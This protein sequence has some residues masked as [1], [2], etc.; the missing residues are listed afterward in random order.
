MLGDPI[1]P[2]NLR[3]STSPV[4]HSDPAIDVAVFQVDGFES[5]P[6][7]QLGLPPVGWLVDGN[8]VMSDA[9]VLG[10]PP[11]PMTNEPYLVVARAQINALVRMRGSEKRHFV[12]SATPRGGFSGGVALHESDFALGVITESCLMNDAPTETGFMT[13]LGT[14]AIFECLAAAKL[15]PKCQGPWSDFHGMQTTVIMRSAS[16]SIGQPV[17][18][19]VMGNNQH[20]SWLELQ[21]NARMDGWK[22]IV[23]KVGAV[24]RIL[25]SD[26]AIESQRDDS[27][28]M[29]LSFRVASRE[30]AEQNMLLLAR[31]AALREVVA[32][33]LIWNADTWA[34]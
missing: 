23:E 30:K 27:E 16:K 18:D 14:G 26:V 6:L 19:L 9:I 28:Y 33:G 31:E 21:V 15:L 20:D 8:W 2:F 10:Y 32:L 12:L 1:G 34:D 22:E 5:A 17:G 13:V 7:L 4:C 11:V 29:R 25:L 3:V 24:I